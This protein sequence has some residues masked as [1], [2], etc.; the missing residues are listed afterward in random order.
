MTRPHIPAAE[1]D[2]ANE[3]PL[4]P[5]ATSD[6]SPVTRAIFGSLAIGMGIAILVIAVL[7]ALFQISPL[8]T[9]MF[10]AGNAAAFTFACL[11][12]ACFIAC[13]SFI[14]RRSLLWT[15][16]FLIAAIALGFLATTIA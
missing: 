7:A 10:D 13:G 11:C 4:I 9:E 8:P 14:L 6:T 5:P 1:R 2:L 3:D 15:A 12:G 16:L